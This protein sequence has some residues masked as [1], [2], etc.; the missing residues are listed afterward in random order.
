MEAKIQKIIDGYAI[1]TVEYPKNEQQ[2]NI[3]IE[4]IKQSLLENGKLKELLD[5]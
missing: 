2:L 3:R 1:K 4:S 5:L